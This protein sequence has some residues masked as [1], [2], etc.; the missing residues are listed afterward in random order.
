MNKKWL[1]G[2]AILFAFAMIVAACGDSDDEGGDATTAAPTETA[3][4][5]APTETSAPE[6]FETITLLVVNNMAHLPVFYAQEL[7]LWAD[8]GL[9]VKVET[10]G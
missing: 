9:D 10:L 8:R 7:G 5:E 3:G 2:L 1:R 4:T 6:E